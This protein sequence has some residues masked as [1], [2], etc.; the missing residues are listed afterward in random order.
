MTQTTTW[1]SGLVL[2]VAAVFVVAAACSGAESGSSSGSGSI[3]PNIGTAPANPT[4]GGSLV[5]ALAAE[6]TGWSPYQGQWGASAFIVANAVFDPLVAFDGEGVAHPYL[7]QSVTPNS[8]FTVWDIGLRPGVTFHNGEK[9][10][11]AA[12]V[13]NLTAARSSGLTG[14]AFQDVSSVEATDELH[15]RVTMQKPFSTFPLLLAG[16]AGYMAAPAQLADPATS[17]T[18]PIG[19][20]PFVFSSWVPDVKVEVVKNPNYWRQGFPR[21][22][23]IEFR[24]LPDS[25][26]RDT[27]MRAGGLN[28]ME[29]AE[30]QTMLAAQARAQAGEGQFYSDVGHE[31]DESVI[32]L[33]TAKP[34]F[35]DPIARQ[36]VAYAIDQAQLSDVTSGGALPPAWGPLA[37]TSPAYLSPQEA[38]VPTTD[39]ERARQLALDYQSAHGQPLEFPVMLPADPSLSNTGQLLQ[40]QLATAGIKAD[41]QLVEQSAMASKV[42]IGD[43]QASAFALFSSPTLDRSYSWIA[44][45]PPESGLS[46]NFTR[47]YDPELTAAM[48]ASRATGDPSARNDDYRT[49]QRRMGADVQMV[50]LTR[51]VRAIASDNQTFG[52]LDTTFPDGGGPAYAGLYSTPFTA[53]AWIQH[54]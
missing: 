18:H 49:V 22:D 31:T 41:L 10:D 38:G 53:S 32:G 44:S 9:L 48:D 25:Q 15:V 43:Y 27:T 2:V 30:P 34:P 5:F 21:L 50:F 28:V 29:T 24:V 13:T 16:Q 40:Q 4:P 54:S 12:V 20:G 39:P 46:L 6:T 51:R 35:D 7:A 8:D 23:A 45:R 19:T 37:P 14:V 52:L 3:A 1:R 11:A 42:L 26:S 36:A 33:N 47:F 17:Q